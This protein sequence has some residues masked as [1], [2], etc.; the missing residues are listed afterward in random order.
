[1]EPMIASRL[2]GLR[3]DR[4]NRVGVNEQFLYRMVCESD[5]GVPPIDLYNTY[6]QHVVASHHHGIHIRLAE[7]RGIP[8][9]RTVSGHQL[10]MGQIARS[11]D[12][13]DFQKLNRIFP[14]IGRHFILLA[15][16]F[17]GKV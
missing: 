7:H 4:R 2:A 17:G 13:T 12:D 16:A 5:L 1:M 15:Q 6:H 3:I 8:G 14:L 11:I 9:I 10:Y